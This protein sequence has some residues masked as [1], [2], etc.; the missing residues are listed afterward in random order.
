M[1]LPS[2]LEPLRL[3]PFCF[4]ILYAY[5]RRLSYRP[6]ARMEFLAFM[7]ILLFPTCA[8][9]IHFARTAK[10]RSDECYCFP[11]SVSRISR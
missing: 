10:Y 9:S 4:S 11:Q 3:N 5:Y 6:S 1:F 8:R 7:D 2:Y